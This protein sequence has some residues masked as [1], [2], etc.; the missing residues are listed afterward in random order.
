MSLISFVQCNI[1]TWAQLFLTIS[2][3]NNHISCPRVTNIAL[4]K[5]C[6]LFSSISE[7]RPTT[8]PVAISCFGSTI[9]PIACLFSINFLT[10]KILGEIS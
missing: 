1:T 8:I 4:F 3:N 2:A 10:A 6:A 9:P 7:N 5:V